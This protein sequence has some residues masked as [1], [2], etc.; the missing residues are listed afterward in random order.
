MIDW[1]LPVAPVIYHLTAESPVGLQSCPM[2][3][4][5]EDGTRGISNQAMEEAKPVAVSQFFLKRYRETAIEGVHLYLATDALPI[6]KRLGVIDEDVTLKDIDG[7]PEASD[8]VPS[9]QTEDGRKALAALYL[10]SVT[11]NLGSLVRMNSAKRPVDVAQLEL[12]ASLSEQRGCLA[13]VLAAIAVGVNQTARRGALGRRKQ[14]DATK[15]RVQAMAD[16]LRGQVSK[17]VAAVKVAHAIGRSTSTVRRL[18]TELYPGS[19]WAR[20][21]R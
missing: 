9:M 13:G 2:Y 16:E 11:K 14:G 12:V 4:S 19:S 15:A 21:V 6:A 20:T 8:R 7:W 3:V 10:M 1:N 5:K 18:L 17:E